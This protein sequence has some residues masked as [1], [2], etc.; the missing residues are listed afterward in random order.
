MSFLLQ[1]RKAKSLRAVSFPWHFS[2]SKATDQ[3]QFARINKMEQ[4]FCGFAERHKDCEQ[5]VHPNAKT[6]RH[7]ECLKTS[8]VPNKDSFKESMD[9]RLRITGRDN[10]GTIGS[11]ND[12][13]QTGASFHIPLERWWSLQVVCC[14]KSF[15][16]SFLRRKTFT[17]SI[18]HRKSN[19]I[20][21]LGY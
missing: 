17:R 13:L 5:A 1:N 2:L 21:Y 4:N 19:S 11:W 8:H 10:F 18:L 20:L 7:L 3:C 9:S 15:P 12:F 16:F 14:R 6:T